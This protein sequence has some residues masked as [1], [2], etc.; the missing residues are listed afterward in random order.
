MGYSNA[1]TRLIPLF[2]LLTLAACGRGELRPDMTDITHVM[3][4]L[5]FAMSR[6]NDARLV[7]AEDYRGKIVLL[8]FGYTHCP[9]ICPA[10]LSNLAQVLQALGP[11]AS[12][13]RVLF[14]SVDPARDTLVSLRAYVHAFAPEVDGLRGSDNEIARLARRYRVLYSV[15][16]T[17]QGIEVMH[18]D[19]VF[20]FDRSG[21]AREVMTNTNNTSAIAGDIENLLR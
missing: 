16:K 12:D 13:V 8:Y 5:K 15:K 11:H 20:L 7:T 3:P 19:S 2:L 1:M 18:S 4:D 10:T 17:D 6:A 9:D 14:V 21:H